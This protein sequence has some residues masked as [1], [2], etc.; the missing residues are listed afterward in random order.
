MLAL[1]CALYAGAQSD[2]LSISQYTEERPLVYED[3]WDLWP[4]AF[5][6]DRG[7]PDG[8]NVDLIKLLMKELHIP[9]TIKLKPSDEAFSDLKNGKSDLML[10][11]AVGFHDEFGSYSKNAVTLFTQSVVTPKSKQIEIKTFRDLGKPGV[12]VI[13]NDSSLCHHLMIDYGWADN[14]VPDKDIR[15]AIQQVSAREDGQ[16][17]W[18]TL[19]LKWL[20]DRYHIENLELTP[21][22]MPHG[23]Y[24]F[25]SNNQRLLDQLD[26]AYTKLNTAERIKPLQDKWFYPERLKP[27]IPSWFWYVLGTGLLVLLTFVFYSISYR[28]Q[29]RRLMREA[30]KRNRRLSLI[31]QT[32]HVRVWTY[33]IK[34]NRF[35]WRNDNGQV[36]YTYTMEEFAQRYSPE[37]F[38]RLKHNMEDLASKPR[39]QDGEEPEITL[40]LK[41]KDTENGDNELRDYFM[42][43][44]VLSRDKEGKATHI[45]GTKKDVTQELEQKRLDDERTLRYWSIFYTPIIGI[46]LFDKNGRLT[47]INPKACELYECDPDVIIERGVG[48]NEFFGLDTDNLRELDG[49]HA[50]QYVNLD[51]IPKEERKVP[52]VRRTGLLCYEYRLMTIDDDGGELLGVFAFCRN[53]MNSLDGIGLYEK[54]RARLSAMKAILAEYDQNIDSVLHESDVRLVTYSPQ[55]HTLTI[56]RSVY[57]EQHRLTQT[58]CMTLVDERSSKMAMRMLNDMDACENREVKVNIRTTLRIGGRRLNLQF[59]LMPQ[60][61]KN[62]QVTEYLGLLRDISRLSEVEHHLALQ[63]EKVQEVENTKNSFVN[64]MVQEIQTPMKTV[65]DHVARLGDEKPS[66]DEAALSKGILDN[67]DY[68][69]HLIDNILYLSRLQANMVEISRTPRNFA[70]VFGAQCMN[71]WKKYQNADT[72]YVVENPYEQLV[73]DID[74]DNLGHA[75][76]QVCTNAAQHTKSGIIRARYD[77][78]GRRLII[79]I[80]DTGEG[81]PRQELQRLNAMDAGGTH[82]TKGLGLAIT[83]ELVR[84]MGGT[85]DISSEEGSGTTV[86]ITIPCHATIIKRNKIV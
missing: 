7:E 11:L 45:I 37:D 82:T 51:R 42:V 77:Y 43:L 21:V 38:L 79:S 86:Y 56:H 24:K 41:A 28:L 5:L 83:K 16:I 23:E 27:G 48:L 49:F 14:A 54:E 53:L 81:I 1:L 39:P 59:C 80:D 12:K 29:S 9:Y 52:E 69:L 8:F 36:A 25:M 62:G 78:I 74:V 47:N 35:S 65:L 3:V 32:S 44:S 61:D 34:A 30:G 15:E 72:R 22:N 19:S 50:T 84:Q 60:L 31:L 10:G 57:E 2:S 20:L 73:V 26:D 18:N 68:L 64:N 17:V 85:V 71:G 58:R 40:N 33:D 67:A 46:M 13:V 70:E 4:Y 55:S 75:I 63:K 66:P 6:N 76:G